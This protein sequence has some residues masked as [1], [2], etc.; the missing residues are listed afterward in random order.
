MSCGVCYEFRTTVVKE[1]HNSTDFIKIGNWIKGA[2]AYYLQSFKDS[3]DIL[4]PG[5]SSHSRENLNHFK[6]IAAPYVKYIEL[7]GI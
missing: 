7:R 1:F 2:N 6:E 3:G 5:L 4:F